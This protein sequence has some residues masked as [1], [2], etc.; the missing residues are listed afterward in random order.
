[1]RENHLLVKLLTT[2][3]K[4]E[5]VTSDER[6]SQ[7]LHWVQWRSQATVSHWLFLQQLYQ[8]GVF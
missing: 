5:A 8:Q 3:V 7:V 6:E 4:T 1:M 2:N